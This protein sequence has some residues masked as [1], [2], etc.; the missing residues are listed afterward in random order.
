MYSDSQIKQFI[1]VAGT[2]AK[3]I[4]FDLHMQATHT[5]IILNTMISTQAWRASIGSFNTVKIDNSIAN[6][7][8][9][10]SCHQM[11]CQPLTFTILSSVLITILLIIGCVESNPGP[12]TPG[13]KGK[14]L[15][16]YNIYEFMKLQINDV[17]LARA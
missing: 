7:Y 8:D 14:C 15:A 9:V 11:I 12:N 13:S 10:S 2:V 6:S 4:V 17:L 16:K 3:T 1:L 5:F